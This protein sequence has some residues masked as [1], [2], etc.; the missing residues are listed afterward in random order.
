MAIFTNLPAAHKL[1]QNIPMN[2]VRS[3][4]HSQS[5]LTHNY[6]PNLFDTYEIYSQTIYI[7]FIHLKFL[8]SLED[9]I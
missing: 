4:I 1:Q 3:H 7:S 2:E 6:P 9:V 8:E 5:E